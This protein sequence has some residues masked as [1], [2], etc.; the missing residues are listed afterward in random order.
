MPRYVHT[1][2]KSTNLS[3]LSVVA[4]N[5]RDITYKST[6]LTKVGGCRKVRS[7]GGGPVVIC[8]RGPRPVARRRRTRREGV[9]TRVLESVQQSH[10]RSQFT[11]RHFNL[12]IEMEIGDQMR[13]TVIPHLK[14]ILH[15]SKLKIEMQIETK[16][17]IFLSV[18][19]LRLIATLKRKLG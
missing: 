17:Y 5:L 6:T 3:I 14:L 19:Q 13:R 9:E 10:F 1:T 2:R 18:E 12:Q 4:H 15:T 11:F 16:L 7:R 8:G